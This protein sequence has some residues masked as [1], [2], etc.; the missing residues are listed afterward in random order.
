MLQ[1]ITC[2]FCNHICIKKGLQKNGAQKL[3]CKN[4]GK[5]QLAQYTN[6]AWLPHTNEMI[7]ILVKE[8]CGI[9]SI[10]RIVKISVTTVIRRIKGIAA[11][12]VKP[13]VAMN[14]EY[15]LDEM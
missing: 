10:A 11:A 8:S 5:H 3:K 13:M 12:I 7:T 1:N 9:R 4:C 6:K 2:H 15:E 14:K